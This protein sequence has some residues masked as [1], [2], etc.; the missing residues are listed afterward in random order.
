MKKFEQALL[1]AE[2]QN[3]LKRV[4]L[5]LDPKIRE[6][7]DY[8][9]YEGYEGYVLS[10]TET[11]VELQ[12]KDKRIMMPKV[13]LENKLIDFIK[14]AA[15]KTYATGRSISD[16]FKDAKNY[17]LDD[18]NASKAEK[19]GRITGGVVGGLTNAALKAANPM[20]YLS[21]IERVAT[22]PIRM[23]GSALGINP[24]KGEKTKLHN[25]GEQSIFTIIPNANQ[26]SEA[27]KYKAAIESNN[28]SWTGRIG[29]NVN[30]QNKFDYFSV[31]N[32]ETNSIN[33][34]FVVVGASTI[35]RIP[36]ARVTTQNYIPIPDT[37]TFTTVIKNFV[38]DTSKSPGST[39][40][41]NITTNFF[42]AIVTIT[43][44]IKDHIEKEGTANIKSKTEYVFD[45]LDINSNRIYQIG[46]HLTSQTG[47]KTFIISQHPE[48]DS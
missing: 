7:Q 17:Y 14:G 37:N 13:A 21:G 6:A 8:S 18:P 45:V 33:P 15:P 28:P 26:L 5:K 36:S 25:F 1:E 10:E 4:R 3:K 34:N 20:T 16:K 40:G 31:R 41:L 22:A 47:G 29:V 11:H 9:Q 48:K 30:P 43:N 38:K 42:N 19:A 24:E 2:Q 23:L 39:L 32:I 35:A 12:I 27:N 44:K 46:G